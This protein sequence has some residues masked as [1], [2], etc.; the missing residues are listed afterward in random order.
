[1]KMKAKLEDYTGKV[2][3]KPLDAI[4]EKCLDCSVYDKNEVKLCPCTDCVLWPFRFGTN[5]YTRKRN[6]SN[7]AREK[8]SKNMSRVRESK[9]NNG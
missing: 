1:M 9:E 7:E 6:I 2:I 5:P 8:L 4:Y 3:E